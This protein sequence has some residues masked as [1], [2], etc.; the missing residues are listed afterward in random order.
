MEG[1]FSWLMC[2]H[3]TRFVDPVASKPNATFPWS[4]SWLCHGTHAT[5]AVPW[6]VK[7]LKPG[8]LGVLKT[9]DEYDSQIP[10]MHHTYGVFFCQSHFFGSYR[11]IAVLGNV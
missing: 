10:L 5:V 2:L 1:F 4:T 6:L 9:L 3:A 11:F 7:L 8:L